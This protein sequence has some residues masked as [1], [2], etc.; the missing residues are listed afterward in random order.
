MS[1][2]KS[3]SISS[4]RDDKMVVMDRPTAAIANVQ[5]VEDTI[6]KEFLTLAWDT[7]FVQ[8][9]ESRLALVI[10]NKISLS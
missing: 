8:M 6:R 4:V 2:F 1:L 7:K 5:E 9:T 3:V 10:F